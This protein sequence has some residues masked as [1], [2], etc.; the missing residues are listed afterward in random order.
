[1]SFYK[2]GKNFDLKSIQTTVTITSHSI[3]AVITI[4]LITYFKDVVYCSTLIYFIAGYLASDKI[5]SGKELVSTIIIL[6]FISVAVLVTLLKYRKAAFG[7]EEEVNIDEIL[8]ARRE[9]KKSSWFGNG[10]N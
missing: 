5:M 8:I 6:S 7:Y 4:V 1:M 2:S 9:H 3:F 10:M